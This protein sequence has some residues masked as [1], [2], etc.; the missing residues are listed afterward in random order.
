MIQDP[1]PL[2]GEQFMIY[3]PYQGRQLITAHLKDGKNHIYLHLQPKYKCWKVLQFKFKIILMFH[4]WF[5]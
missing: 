3:G 4:I 1:V 2:D 5:I